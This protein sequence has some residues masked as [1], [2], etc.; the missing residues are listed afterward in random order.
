[1]W[2]SIAVAAFH[3]IYWDQEQPHFSAKLLDL[4]H[5]FSTN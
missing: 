1:M 5:Q 4:K 3:C 2:I